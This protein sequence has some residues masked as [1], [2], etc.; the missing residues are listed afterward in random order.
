MAIP[1]SPSMK[2]LSNLFFEQPCFEEGSAATT[3]DEAEADAWSVA[4]EDGVCF[5]VDDAPAL[6]RLPWGVKSAFERCVSEETTATTCSTAA[7]TPEVSP[8][9]TLRAGEEPTWPATLKDA[10]EPIMP[11]NFGY[12]G[13]YSPPSVTGFELIAVGRDGVAHYVPRD[14]D[15]PEARGDVIA[16]A[17]DGQANFVPADFGQQTIGNKL[18]SLILVSPDGSAHYRRFGDLPEDW[19][20]LELEPEVQSEANTLVAAAA[21]KLSEE[22]CSADVLHL[23]GPRSFG[24]NFDGQG[25]ESD[26]ED[27]TD[28]TPIAAHMLRRARGCQG[29]IPRSPS[30]KRLSGNL[31]LGRRLR[32]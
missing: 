1:R 9:S 10:A 17:R 16:V 29:S 8:Q 28:A 20:Q 19:D 24:P 3:E 14:F 21:V 32:M 4:E 2:K 26:S 12:D 7:S 25:E 27:T 15:D 18:G 13:F 11:M 31:F 5:N 23:G 30:L 6:T 22:M